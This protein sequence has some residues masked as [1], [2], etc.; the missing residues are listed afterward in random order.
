MD[1]FLPHA[2]RWLEQVYG[3]YS[4]VQAESLAYLLACCFADGEMVGKRNA[5]ANG[6]DH[7]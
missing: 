1:T 4:K 5:K 3:E 6:K 2:K 7:A